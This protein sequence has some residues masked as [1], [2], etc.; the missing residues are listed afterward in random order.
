MM[1]TLSAVRVATI[2]CCDI[3]GTIKG[4]IEE[5]NSSEWLAGF[6]RL[7]TAKCASCPSP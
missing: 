7:F 1:K 3:N 5:Q 4:L 6:H 2:Y